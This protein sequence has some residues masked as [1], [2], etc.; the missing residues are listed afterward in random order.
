MIKFPYGL[1]DF[2]DI[3]TE[4]YFYIDR[5]DRLPL[6]EEAGKQLLFLRPRRFGKSLLLSMLENYYDIAGVDQFESLFGRL[7]IGENP[8]KN[9]NRYFVLKWD[10]SSVGPQN[11]AR[12]LQK[13]L[14]RYLNARIR[15]FSVKYKRL[16]PGEIRIE[17]EDALI[18]FQSLLTAVKQTSHRLYLLIDEYDNFA[19]EIFMKDQEAGRAR[20]NTLLHGE[21]ELKALFKVVK[22]AAAGLGLDRVF[23]TGV[24]PV[25]MSDMTSGYNIAEDISLEP[26]FNDL[27]GF[28]EPEIMDALHR[29]AHA[30]G[31]PGERAAEA[32]S[33]M[34]A[35]YNGYCFSYTMEGIVYNPTLALYFMKRFQKRGQYPR[36]MLDANMAMD[37]GKLTYISGLPNG[38]RLILDALDEKQPLSIVE[39][40]DRFGVEDM[41]TAVKDHVFMA[42]LLYYFGILTLGGEAPFGKII[43]KP[44]NL[45]V[46]KLYMEKIQSMLLPDPADVDDSRKAAE[47]LQQRGEMRPLCDF[48]ETRCFKALNNRDYRW[49]N[50]LTIK[51]A[52]LTLLFNDTF[53]IIDSEP[54]LER[55]YA[56][57]TMIVRPD[58]RRHKLLD[59]LI[60]F[61]YISLPDAGLSG[62]EIKGAS[63]EDLV[64]L[65]PVQH[66]L[67]DSGKKLKRYGSA[68]KARHGGALRLR[69]FSVVALGFDR[70]AWEEV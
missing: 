11:D 12:E 58:M 68:L 56:D 39:M 28:R 30:R 64:A 38:E 53:Y 9:H 62:E 47:A 45:V 29:I 65:P 55:G 27:C 13:A 33:M 35:F 57:L 22:S 50:E 6:I 7:A 32:I 52:F 17:P 5:S 15:D 18:S 70:L 19:N 42:S 2:H 54:A 43:L 20:Y 1:C 36:K 51:T 10:F 46:R 31:L 14:H 60:E 4:D 40:A 8:T 61:K 59:I 21:G 24:S 63:K 23:I 3:V 49:A 48:I 67:A 69:S 16:L 26:E 41:L 66:A 25:V 37:R 34:R 44:P